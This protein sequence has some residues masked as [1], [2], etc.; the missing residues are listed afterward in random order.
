[1]QRFRAHIVAVLTVVM[2]GVLVM[3]A[4]AHQS[5]CTSCADRSAE[6]SCCATGADG[7]AKKSCCQDKAGQKAGGEH[8]KGCCGNGAEC[9]GCCPMFVFVSSTSNIPEAAAYLEIPVSSVVERIHFASV[10]PPF[11]PPRI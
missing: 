9:C 1:M 3:P 6:V 11:H 2:V 5:A 4:S 7:A 10:D 8:R